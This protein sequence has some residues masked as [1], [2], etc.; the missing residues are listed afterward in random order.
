MS[1]EREMEDTRPG[2]PGVKTGPTYLELMAYFGMSR[3]SGGWTAT[4]ELVEL[5][6]IRPEMRVLDVGCGIGKT[7]CFLT[8]RHGCHVVGVDLSARMIGWAEET[9][10]QEGVANR[11][12][13]RVADARDLPFEDESFDVV[14]SES[15]LSFVSDRRK[16]LREYLRVTRPAGYVGLNESSCLAPPSAEMIAFIDRT[17]VGASLDTVD[18]WQQRLIDLGLKDVEVRAHR[19]TPRGEVLDRIRWFGWRGLFRNIGHMVSFSVAS[20]ANRRVLKGYMDVNRRIP[21]AFYEQYAYGIYVG[22]KSEVT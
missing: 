14:I 21:P 3:H 10:R 20:P 18:T 7:A 17:F 22:R 6:H 5:C 15:V 19:L 4:A 9:G 1:G 2:S 11:V 13:F 12:E 8:K 16:A